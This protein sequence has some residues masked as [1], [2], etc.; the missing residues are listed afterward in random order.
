MKVLVTGGAGF[1]GS[2]LVERLLARGDE[3]LVI[4]NYSTGRRDTLGTHRHLTVVEGTIADAEV[5]RDAFDRC[6]PN[7]VVH[8]AASYKNPHDWAEDARTNVL[9]TAHV[10]QACQRVGVSRVI[11]LQTA[12]CYGL[13]P[14]EQPVTLDHP[15]RPEASSYAI[16]KTAG[17]HYVRLSGL[18]W[19]SFRLANMYG[20]RNLS[21]PLPTFYH[22]L[23]AGKPCFVM[24]TRRDFVFVNDLIDI[25]VPAVDGRGRS[26]P[27]HVSSGADY[28]IKDLFDAAVE[29]LG[30]T[31]DRPVEVR[32]RHDND[33][34]TILI[35][36]SAAQQDFGW[37]TRTPLREG[38]ATAL[39]WYRK[40]GLEETYTHLTL[41]EKGG[42][43]TR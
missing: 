1:I 10:V 17:E 2:H 31:L 34:Y 12:L 7:V 11:Y 43:A 29:G 21:G 18:N 19:I 6:Q 16:S 9:G 23:T 13:L 35:D 30:I 41:D 5:V 28:S 15:I 27:Y 22:R 20:P 38:V 32:P 39:A 40:Y 24:D 25:L 26:G 42:T 3:V 8:A 14:L 37:K 4:D 33:A 36:P